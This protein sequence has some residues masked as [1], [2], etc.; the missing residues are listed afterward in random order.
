[1]HRRTL[2]AIGITCGWLAAIGERLAGLL[3]DMLVGG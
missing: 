3:D 1:M 2:S